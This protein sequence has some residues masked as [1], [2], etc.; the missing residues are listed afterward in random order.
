MLSNMGA[1]IIFTFLARIKLFICP[2]AGFKPQKSLILLHKFF[3]VFH[4]YYFIYLFFW[5]RLDF[6]ISLFSDIL[7]VKQFRLPIETTVV[8]MLESGT[9]RKS[10]T[11]QQAL[12]ISQK[13]VKGACSVKQQGFLSFHQI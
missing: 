10:I 8:A 11:P 2:T 5:E 6:G 7:E 1:I 3:L 4:F 13:H 12:P 9:N